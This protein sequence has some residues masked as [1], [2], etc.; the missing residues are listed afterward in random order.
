MIILI[1][2]NPHVS[3]VCR[4]SKSLNIEVPYVWCAKKGG[5]EVQSFLH[6][7]V[8]GACGLPNYYTN[9]L[10]LPVGAAYFKA[11]AITL[12]LNPKKAKK[13]VPK[14]APKKA[15]TTWEGVAF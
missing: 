3:F 1:L 8:T 14:K 6:F 13:P 10:Y 5:K 11:R 4:G 9:N 7:T 2:P 12:R 15:L